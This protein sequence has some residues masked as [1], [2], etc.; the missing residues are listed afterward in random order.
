MV[1]KDFDR[2]LSKLGEAIDVDLHI[3]SF[4]GCKIAFQEGPSVQ[5]ELSM[6]GY[7][8]FMVSELGELDGGRYREDLMK[9][10]LKANGLPERGPGV[11]AFNESNNQLMLYEQFP[12]DPIDPADVANKLAQFRDKAK[13]W[14]E[15]LEAGRVPMVHS[16]TSSAPSGL[17][18][19]QP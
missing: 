9:E 13:T 12:S 7:S 17:F 19:L 2:F 8:I 1:P 4:D 14:S 15:D 6:D 5:L 3:D 16:G 18:G 10:A 11:L